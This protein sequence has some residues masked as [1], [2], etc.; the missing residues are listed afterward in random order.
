MQQELPSL[1]QSSPLCK[2]EKQPSLPPLLGSVDLT[3]A[4]TGETGERKAPAPLP[5]CPGCGPCLPSHLGGLYNSLLRGPSSDFPETLR[6]HAAAQSSRSG[7]HSFSPPP[8]A[9]SAFPAAYSFSTCKAV[10]S[11]TAHTLGVCSVKCV[12]SSACSP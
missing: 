8:P 1:P 4:R 11:F 3:G 9:P 10:T 7:P 2:E 6:L 12:R 5:T